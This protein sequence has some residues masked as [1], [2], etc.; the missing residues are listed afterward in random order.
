MKI[1]NF[2]KAKAL[3]TMLP[4]NV[5]NIMPKSDNVIVMIITSNV[6]LKHGVRITGIIRRPVLYLPL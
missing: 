3:P 4:A 5:R 1:P 2:A 6:T